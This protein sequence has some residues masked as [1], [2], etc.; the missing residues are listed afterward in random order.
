MPHAPAEGLERLLREHRF[1]LEALPLLHALSAHLGLE[2]AMAPLLDLAHKLGR[3]HGH[4]DVEALAHV[5]DASHP[6]LHSR[7]HSTA[8][9]LAGLPSSSSM[10]HGLFHCLLQV[11]VTHPQP[12]S[13]RLGTQGKP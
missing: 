7:A 10:I 5:F 4:G 1:V 9:T 6:V 11:M 13:L 2:R 3:H 8:S 12:T